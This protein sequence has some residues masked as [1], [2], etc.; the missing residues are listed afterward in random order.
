MDI[1]LLTS[2]AKW[3]VLEIIAKKEASPLEIARQLKTSVANI[4]TQ[5]RYL[6]LAGIVKKRRILNA[7]ANMPRIM[8]SLNKNLF[9]AMA[10]GDKFH[11]RRLIDLD[12]DKE[13]LLR[14]WQLPKSLH[15]PLLHLYVKYPAIFGETHSVYYSEHGD[16]VVKLILVNDKKPLPSKV[17]SIEYK[18]KQYAFDIHFASIEKVDMKK[19]T[20]ISPGNWAIS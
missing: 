14:F 12:L 19:L 9:L 3:A 13:M 8:Y 10:V 15:G 11:T 5:L 16:S 2:K 4:S 18:D 6:E 1:D 7:Q 20:L 17:I